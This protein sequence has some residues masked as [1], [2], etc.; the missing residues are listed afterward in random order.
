M[1]DRF[2][3]LASVAVTVWLLLYKRIYPYE[4]DELNHLV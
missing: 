4:E 1:L 3:R 2:Q